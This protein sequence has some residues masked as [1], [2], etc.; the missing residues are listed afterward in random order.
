MCQS[1]PLASLA[2]IPLTSCL[3][4]PNP[5]LRDI[6]LRAPPDALD[7]PADTLLTSTA[8]FDFTVDEVIWLGVPGPS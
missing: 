2:S 4:N 6:H 8:I 3:A 1:L 7:V 5:T